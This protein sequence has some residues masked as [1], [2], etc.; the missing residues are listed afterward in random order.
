MRRK[1]NYLREMFDGP[2]DNRWPQPKQKHRKYPKRAMWDEETPFT[3]TTRK[4]RGPSWKGNVSAR[5][6]TRI[7]R[8]G[9]TD[10]AY[11][12]RATIHEY[13]PR[14]FVSEPGVSTWQ[15]GEDGFYRKRGRPEVLRHTGGGWEKAFVL[16]NPHRNYRAPT[17]FRR[18]K[19]SGYNVLVSDVRF[20]DLPLAIQRRYRTPLGYSS[21]PPFYGYEFDTYWID[22]QPNAV[23]YRWLL[24]WARNN[25]GRLYTD[26]THW[27]RVGNSEARMLRLPRR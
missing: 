21:V 6:G 25:P 18:A 23:F 20:E 14:S 17:Y 15:Q 19:V 8:L 16:H 3:E 5:I 12:H 9:K 1:K 13:G 22:R 7:E 2:S 26:T 24:T 27:T 4:T 11:K 10:L